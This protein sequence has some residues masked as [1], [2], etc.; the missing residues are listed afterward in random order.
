MW[1]T[2]PPNTLAINC[3]LA[4]LVSGEL[5]IAAAVGGTQTGALM[6]EAGV[7]SA[8]LSRCATRQLLTSV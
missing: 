4:W 7:T 3:R 2:G 6:R 5:K 8:G 1:A